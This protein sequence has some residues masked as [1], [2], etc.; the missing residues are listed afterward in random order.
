MLFGVY[1]GG[2]ICGCSE[3]LHI[4]AAREG[5]GDATFEPAFLCSPQL[6][7]EFARNILTMSSFTFV[8]LLVC[9]VGAMAFAP[10][11]RFGSGK[12]QH[13]PFRPPDARSLATA[14]DRKTHIILSFPIVFLPY[15]VIVVSKA[16]T[17]SSVSSPPP[18]YFPHLSPLR[19]E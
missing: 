18:V 1:I 17:K 3:R 4:Q 15:T 14:T 12:L 8:L 11:A 5:Q 9:I 2:T 19:A 7:T 13:L 6:P 16:S 10:A